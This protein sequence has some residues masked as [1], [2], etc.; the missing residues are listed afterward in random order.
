MMKI[1]SIEAVP[2][3][4]PYQIANVQDSLGTY[5]S[6]SHGIIIIYDE[7]GNY[8][9]G[10]IALAW[11]GGAHSLCREVNEYWAS[12]LIGKEVTDLIKITGIL[13]EMVIFSQRHL[14]AK[15]GVE[16][17]LFDLLGKNLQMPIYKLLGGKTREYIPLTGGITIDTVDRMVESAKKNV[18]EGFKELK[19]KV[20]LD[21]KKDLE[22]VRKVRDAIPDHIKLRVDANMAWHEPKRVKKLID[23]MVKYGVTI[24]EQPLRKDQLADLCWLRN[25]TDALILLDESVWD[26]NDAKNCL[27]AG[28][29]DLLHV[30][31]S[32]AGGFHSS[33]RIFELASL[34]DVNCTI[35]GMPEARIGASASLHLGISM[36]NLSDYSSD[37]RGFKIYKEDVVNEELEIS[38]GKLFVNDKPGLGVTLDFDK[39]DKLRIK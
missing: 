28:A 25:N 36:Q 31:V 32:E 3:V 35:G 16:M 39:L 26:I 34:F 15:A 4:L 6:S 21:D 37:V 22:A 23:E 19:L 29:G 13:D 9:I 27:L 33:R 10:E 1:V 30:Y 7:S 8:G 14:L 24:V 18:S 17:A 12:H 11:F 2:V 5:S 38:D 20:G